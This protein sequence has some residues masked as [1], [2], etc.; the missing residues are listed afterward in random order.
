MIL[1]R[2]SLRLRDQKNLQTQMETE[3]VCVL[4]SRRSYRILWFSR[5]P[6]VSFPLTQNR[7]TVTLDTQTVKSLIKI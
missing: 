2:N 6:I 3:T 1:I 7:I 4:S 5:F